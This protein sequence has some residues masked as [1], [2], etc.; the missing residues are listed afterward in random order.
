MMF[1]AHTIFACAGR[2]VTEQLSSSSMSVECRGEVAVIHGGTVDRITDA[3]GTVADMTAAELV[4]SSPPA[5]RPRR[6]ELPGSR[7]RAL[8]LSRRAHG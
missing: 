3:S 2:A 4:R 5:V 1:P 7:G 6:R 8:P